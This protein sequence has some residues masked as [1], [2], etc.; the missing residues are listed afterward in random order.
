[1]VA[2]IRES[3]SDSEL[4]EEV[5]AKVSEQAWAEKLNLQQKCQTLL[6]QIRT[7]GEQTETLAASCDT[8]KS[9][10]A[11]ADLNKPLETAKRHLDESELELGSLTAEQVDT[12]AV[13]VALSNVHDLWTQLRPLPQRALAATI[14]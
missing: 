14:T 13:S 11:L 9:V 7:A 3:G 10:S 4:I 12:T 5:T 2:Q 1:M 6:K 8:T